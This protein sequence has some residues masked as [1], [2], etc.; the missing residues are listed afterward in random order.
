MYG[1]V[2]QERA[3][4]VMVAPGN[5]R[6]GVGV[7]QQSAQVTVCAMRV[8]VGAVVPAGEVVRDL[9]GGVSPIGGRLNGRCKGHI[10]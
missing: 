7:M 3:N 8:Y 5:A 6:N 4:C 10:V 2:G 9:T 1:G